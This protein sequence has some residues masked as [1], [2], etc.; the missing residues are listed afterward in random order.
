MRALLASAV[1]LLACTPSTPAPIAVQCPP[2]VTCPPPAPDPQLAQCLA[3]LATIRSQAQDEVRQTIK[4]RLLDIERWLGARVV[5]DAGEFID[6][7]QTLCQLNTKALKKFGN[8]EVMR[9]ALLSDFGISLGTAVLNADCGKT[10]VPDWLANVPRPIDEFYAQVYGKGQP[11]EDIKPLLNLKVT[12]QGKV[13]T[14]EPNAVT[15]EGKRPAMV[16][17]FTDGAKLKVG[18]LVKVR[19]TVTGAMLGV[20]LK[21]CEI[22]P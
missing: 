16:V 4:R 2:P 7:D 14:V 12:I 3:T 5:N 15:I 1:F 11:A 20:Q 19:G 8:R 18:T 13:M 22:V 9:R 6:L 21:P 10:K 17:C